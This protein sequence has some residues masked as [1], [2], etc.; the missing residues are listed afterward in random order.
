MRK[1]RSYT[2]KG[3]C[4]STRCLPLKDEREMIYTKLQAQC[5]KSKGESTVYIVNSDKACIS[6]ELNDLKYDRVE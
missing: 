3:E 2:Y 6:T 5:M 4:S 1:W